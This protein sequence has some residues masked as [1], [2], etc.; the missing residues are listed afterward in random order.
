[1]FPGLNRWYPIK[2]G[3]KAAYAL[4][5]RHYSFNAYAD[6]RRQDLS[7]RNR[8]LF[9]GPGES[10]VLMTCD[11]LAL[12]VWRKFIDKS[13]E[14]GVNCAV[15]HNEGPHLSSELIVEAEELAW[16]KWPG[17]RLYTYIDP[18]A[19]RTGRPKTGKPFVGKCY[20]KAGWTKLPYTT[21]KNGLYVFEKLPPP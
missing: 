7:Y 6:G 10:L 2:D 18:K 3:N 8:H 1:M 17:E 12:F 5:R 13:G 14:V 21:K 11:S 15:F 9:V 4:M 19:V 16:V 20:T